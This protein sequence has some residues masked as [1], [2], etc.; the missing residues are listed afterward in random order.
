VIL[1]RM[2]LY[3]FN[4]IFVACDCYSVVNGYEDVKGYELSMFSKVG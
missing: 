2:A 4:I 3:S 1:K